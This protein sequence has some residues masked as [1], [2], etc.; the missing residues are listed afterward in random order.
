MYIKIVQKKAHKNH[1]RAKRYKTYGKKI[2]NGGWKADLTT[3]FSNQH[4]VGCLCAPIWR[5]RVRW[6]NSKNYMVGLYSA[7]RDTL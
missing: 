1:K 2:V 5:T 7:Y 3:N 4:T 6:I